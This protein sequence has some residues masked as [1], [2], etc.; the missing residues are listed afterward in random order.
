MFTVW[1]GLFSLVL[2]FAGL[3]NEAPLLFTVQSKCIY[4]I[5]E[6]EI[7][8]IQFPFICT[9]PSID[10]HKFLSFKGWYYR[11][12]FYQPSVPHCRIEWVDLSAIRAKSTSFFRSLYRPTAVKG[13]KC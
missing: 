6:A 1:H 12:R 11:G 2:M 10:K 7:Q 4:T 8:E 5:F 3:R 9:K 13:L